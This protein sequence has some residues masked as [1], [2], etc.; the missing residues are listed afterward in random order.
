MIITTD[1]R[2]PLPNGKITDDLEI[3][4]RL[5]GGGSCITYRVKKSNG[6]IYV[7]KEI[8][9]LHM[10]DS[11]KRNGLK[12]EAVCM[13]EAHKLR[14]S[15]L[16]EAATELETNKRVCRVLGK[17]GKENNTIFH[18]LNEDITDRIIR[19]HPECQDTLARY[20]LIDTNEGITLSEMIR[21]NE[22]SLR[23]I[24]ELM[25]TI[26]KP[27]KRMHEELHMVHLDL[28]WENIFVCTELK[29]HF[30]CK[31]LDCGQAKTIGE[32]ECWESSLTVSADFAAPEQLLIKHLMAGRDI[33]KSLQDIGEHTDCYAIMAM[34]LR[35]LINCNDD[36]W[37]RFNYSRSV[38][39]RYEFIK[40]HI[41]KKT[42][43]DYF[44][45]TD[46]LTEFFAYGLFYHPV[47]EWKTKR[48]SCNEMERK[49]SILLEILSSR[50][51]HPEIVLRK[52]K[53][54][55]KE[56]CSQIPNEEWLAEIIEE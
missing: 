7:L 23:E 8:Y 41:A 18:F 52:S 20:I 16:H 27:V 14:Q 13:E 21:E 15:F 37:R 35:M 34:G 6:G 22:L 2:V 47:D 48:Y 46:K 25:L 19:F 39:D 3:V 12:L 1:K 40:R 43:G 11:L 29:E 10:A 4:G 44:Y 32:Q 26:C 50:G 17:G 54:R 33:K 53:E 36:E 55:Y 28:K 56:F 42:K 31:L 49:I 9:P 45:L 51:F 5:S 30:W 38:T 24:L